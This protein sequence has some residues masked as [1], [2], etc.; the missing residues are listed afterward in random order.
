MRQLLLLDLNFN[1][2]AVIDRF[3]SL[4]WT[5]RFWEYGDF[6]LYLKASTEAI[7]LIKEGWYLYSEESDNIMIIE[8]R[9]VETDVEN[10]DHLKITGRSLASIITRRII[11]TQTTHNGL[12][13]TGIQKFLTENLIN[14][15]VAVRKIPNFIFET[16][17]DASIL[18]LPLTAQYTG[19][20][21]Y[22]VIQNLC[23]TNNI[24]F[25]VRL[26]DSKQFVFS[27]YSGVDR[28]YNQTTNPYVVFSPKF[29][30]LISSNYLESKKTLMTSAMI[31]GEGEGLDRR[32]YHLGITAA[33]LDRR[34]LDVDARDI[35]SDD[36]AIGTT[37]YNNLLKQ[38]GQE[39][40][41]EHKE[42]L[43]FEA[44]IDPNRSFR[45]GIDYNM[46]DI[47]SIFN[48][49]NQESQSRILE[50]VFTTDLEGT[51]VIPTFSIVPDSITS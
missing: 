42:T 9:E 50:I 10:G 34:E 48:N 6:E 32:V 38:R 14:P 45:Y 2:V 23:E 31:R 40:L 33:G 18:A 29:D 13:W 30:N 24:G 26:N 22:E 17:T 36:G 3:E 21:L 49:Y 16:P 5:D 46:G 41:A 1:S 7:D 51:T 11:W 27:L 25:K 28:S 20:N 19:D 4:I 37:A 43:S 44:V 8:D 15:S 39:K 12:L 35:S 47:V